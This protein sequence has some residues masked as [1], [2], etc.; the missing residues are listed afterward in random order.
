MSIPSLSDSSCHKDPFV[1]LWNTVFIED[2]VTSAA[3]LL[4]AEVAEGWTGPDVNNR[5][6]LFAAAH[7]GAK[8]C[9]DLLLQKSGV[10]V[11]HQDALRETALHRACQSGHLDCVQ[12]L[13][14]AGADPVAQSFY[15][16]TPL[17]L[18]TVT[19]SAP[20]LIRVLMGAGADPFIKDHNG[21]TAVDWAADRGL[22]W[23]V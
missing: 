3:D 5:T 18:A 20:E 13:L 17:H 21:L 23:P 4:I 2:D 9:L 8:K 22:T 1:C 7:F 14:R 12:S 11:R 16:I 6:R 19:R 15:R 10:D